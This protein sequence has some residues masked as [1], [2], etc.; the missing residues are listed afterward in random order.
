SLLAVDTVQRMGLA[1]V[2][3]TLQ[4]AGFDCSL[5]TVWSESDTPRAWHYLIEVEGWL[6]A[7]DSRLERLRRGFAEPID[8]LL[9]L[10]GYALPL[11]AESI[12][13]P[14]AAADGHAVGE[15]VAAG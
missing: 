15:G 1:Q 12:A 4:E 2:G 3:R 11:S 6:G 7:D 9:L 14:S 5:L 8:R 10:G 13:R